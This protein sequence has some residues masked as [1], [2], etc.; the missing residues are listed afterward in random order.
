[1]M[2]L[3]TL[4]GLFREVWDN[5][6]TE[7]EPDLRTVADV[8]LDVDTPVQAGPPVSEPGG[9]LL[10]WKDDLARGLVVDEQLRIAGPGAH[11]LGSRV[12]KE[13]CQMCGMPIEEH[14]TF[15]DLL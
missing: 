5:I 3:N 6:A 2:D 4:I 10:L 11:V 8:H 12:D 9:D 15:E 13:R 14:V 7:R 1:M